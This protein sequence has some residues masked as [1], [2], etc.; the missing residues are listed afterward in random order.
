MIIR[1][2]SRRPLRLL[3]GGIGASWH[4]ISAGPRDG[5]A[6]SAWGGHPP[7]AD[8]ARWQE[9][10]RHADWLGLNFVRVELEQK[11]YQPGRATFTWESEDL[12][13]LRRIL[14]W[15]QS[16]GV[17]VILQQM[18]G[19]VEWNS[20]PEVDALHSAPFDLTAWAEGLAILVE[21]VVREWGYTCIQWICVNNEPECSF[22]WW[23]GHGLQPLKILPG[24]K[25]AR[26]ALDR[27]GIA[28]PLVGPDY[29]GLG[30]PVSNGRECLPCLGAV[31]LHT[32]LDDFR[33][34]PVGAA[35]PDKQLKSWID[36]ANGAGLPFF[37]TE[38]G[39]MRYGWY[40][41]SPAPGGYLA[42]LA[43]AE[44]I[45][46]GLRLGVEGFNRWSFINRGDL[47]GQWQLIDTWDAATDSLLP[48]FRPH[49]NAYWLFGLITRFFRKRSTLLATELEDA[50]IKGWHQYLL[51]E[52]L[53]S[54][55]GHVSVF[56][57]S[58]TEQPQPFELRLEGLDPVRTFHRYRVTEAVRNRTDGVR[59]DPEADWRL[60]AG[61]PA[62]RDTAPGLSL[63]VY[64][65][66]HLRHD[67]LA[68]G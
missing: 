19:N 13:A 40:T 51:A 45:L 16:R 68:A 8:E 32:Y 59:L 26:A 34:M 46:R 12:R 14:D 25:A 52:A 20:Y 47:D 24:L 60:G 64:S 6:G 9:I 67:D 4:A 15:C 48:A 43:N 57:L 62:L 23:Q 49:P 3:R 63:T 7:A 65:T 1:V 66:R 38:F 29:T 11:S 61:Q 22:S 33:L 31:D 10:Y 44:I 28:V 35:E 36:L 2:D 18:W 39:C 5:G 58:H 50:V 55:D 53:L 17:D 42:N 54:A 30:W 27:R 41:D 21:K 56:V 37:F